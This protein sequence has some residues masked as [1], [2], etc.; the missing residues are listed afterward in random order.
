MHR[1]EKTYQRWKRYKRKKLIKKIILLFFVAVLAILGLKFAQL[2]LQ[3]SQKSP[4]IEPTLPA[5]ATPSATLMPSL[6][7]E[8]KLSSI[9]AQN[10]KK[11]KKPKKQKS[12][13]KSPR[14]AAN[15]LSFDIRS[16]SQPLPKLIE[17]FEN[18][19]TK[20]LA[21]LIAKKQY[22]KG[23]YKKALH[24][25]M[26]ASDLGGGKDKE[27]WIIFAKSLYKLG[28]RQ[29]A[30]EVLQSYLRHEDSAQIR[31]LLHA[32]QQGKSIP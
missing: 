13:K 16:K 25:S 4:K 24:W 20:S 22:Q 19:P 14:A 18:H 23:E 29:E 7:F 6:D 9:A 5:T 28:K 2:P 27:N 12:T 3:I 32:M 1:Y 30:M 11:P 10:S 15:T 31:S 17:K 26:R 8:S 21:I